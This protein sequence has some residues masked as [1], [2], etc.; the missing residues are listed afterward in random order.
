MASGSAVSDGTGYMKR[1][2]PDATI[3]YTKLWY[4]SPRNR[5]IPRGDIP[6]ARVL[7]RLRRTEE[8]EFSGGRQERLTAVVVPGHLADAHGRPWTPSTKRCDRSPRWFLLVPLASGQRAVVSYPSMMVI[9]WQLRCSRQASAI[10]RSGE[11]D[12]ANHPVQPMSNPG[13]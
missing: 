13:E 12:S 1:R 3:E 2:V 7:C 5:K 8:E 6:G 11:H 10:C 9:E 4:I